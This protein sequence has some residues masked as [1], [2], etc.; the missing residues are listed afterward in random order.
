MVNILWLT[1]CGEHFM[2]NILW[3]TEHLV[4]TSRQLY[5][6]HCHWGTTSIEHYEILVTLEICDQSDEETGFD[7]QKYKNNDKYNYKNKYSAMVQSFQ[8]KKLVSKGLVKSRHYYIDIDIQEQ[9][10]KEQHGTAF[11]QCFSLHTSI[12]PHPWHP[13]RNLWFH[14]SAWIPPDIAFLTSLWVKLKTFKEQVPCTGCPK[15]NLLL[16]N[17][18]W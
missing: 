4:V 16:Y 13:V 5:E 2:V 17:K 10:C 7:H 9:Q 18:R 11:L 15:K 14:R 8:T 6:L 1:S 12:P 3:W